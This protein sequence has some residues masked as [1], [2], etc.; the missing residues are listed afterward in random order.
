MLDPTILNFI[1]FMPEFEMEIKS[2]LLKT[3]KK[4]FRW[5]LQKWID[6]KLYQKFRPDLCPGNIDLPNGNAEYVHRGKPKY[7]IKNNM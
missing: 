7:T 1:G 6:I 3:D 4:L 5:Q 2:Y